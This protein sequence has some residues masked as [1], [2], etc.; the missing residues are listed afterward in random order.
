MTSVS[1]PWFPL[2]PILSASAAALMLAAG[3]SAEELDPLQ[4]EIALVRQAHD[5]I[6]AGR[7]AQVESQLSAASR[8]KESLP[9]SVL[10]ARRAAMLCG[11]LQNDNDYGRAGKVA[12]RAVAQLSAMKETNDADRAERLYWEALLVGRML[13]QKK[14]A[15]ELLERAKTLSPE[16][17]RILELELAFATAVA[18]FGR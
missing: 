15:L 7:D 16:D 8:L 3:A 1:L 11:W 14:Q 18:A 10:L 9:S 4:H 5:A 2:R 12:Q 17:D 13:D 6:R